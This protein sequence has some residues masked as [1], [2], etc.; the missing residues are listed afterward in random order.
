MAA[1]FFLAFAY[2]AVGQATVVRN[3]AQTAADSAALAAAMDGR[4][5]VHDA[6]LAAL[7]AGDVEK[8]KELL[9]QD[10]T[11]SVSACAKA[12]EYAQD[13]NAE[14]E[15]CGQVEDPAGYDVSVKSLGSVGKSV[16]HG[17]ENVHAVAHATA[18]VKPR[19]TVDGTQG[20]AVKLTCDK[21][22]VTVDP[23]S[24]GYELDLS[25][26][27]TVRLSK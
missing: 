23:T 13:N 2:F 17:T 3:T 22:D 14:V 15:D 11:D 4:N 5:Q 8:L 21:G 9:Q 16:V 20:A 26:F 1:L 12:D 27:Y 19:C 25:T 6:F 10:G 7:K 24:D 18:V